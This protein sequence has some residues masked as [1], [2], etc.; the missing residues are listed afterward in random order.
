MVTKLGVQGISD[1]AMPLKT[2]LFAWEKMFEV[3]SNKD[4]LAVAAEG[5]D[6]STI[7]TGKISEATLLALD[8]ASPILSEVGLQGLALFLRENMY[9]RRGAINVVCSHRK[10][11]N[12]TLK[13][14]VIM[15]TAVQSALEDSQAGDNSRTEEIMFRLMDSSWTG[16]H[17][18][19]A[20]M[21]AWV[22]MMMLSGAFDSESIVES[23]GMFGTSLRRLDSKK[24]AA[25][26][27]KVSQARPFPPPPLLCFP[28]LFPH[29]ILNCV[30][31]PSPFRQPLPLPLAPTTS[32][33][34]TI[35][36]ATE[37]SAWMSSGRGVNRHRSSTQ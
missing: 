1:A 11:K 9:A 29:C 37:S 3:L 5:G 33:R 31:P 17:V 7:N 35:K 28:P 22:T 14:F 36:T 25:H 30:R 15:L 24:L 16:T 18:T 32:S 19:K 12:V 21:E 2:C 26:F 13:D 34:P 6:A 4:P 8:V 23:R 10:D 20:D 27:L